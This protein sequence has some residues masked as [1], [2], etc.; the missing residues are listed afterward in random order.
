MSEPAEIPNPENEGW[1]ILELFGH[2]Q[3]AGYTRE[4]M[5]AGKL[6]LRIDVPGR[7]ATDAPRATQ[8][9]SPAA[10]YSLTPTTEA[11]ARSI[12]A[13][14]APPESHFGLLPE[15]TDPRESESVDSSVVGPW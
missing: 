14:I 3:L 4:V 10:V 1:H 8:K 7:L 9:Y 6:F 12:A 2:R 15:R 11:I 5:V 13:R